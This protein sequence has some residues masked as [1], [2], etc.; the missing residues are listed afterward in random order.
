MNHVRCLHTQPPPTTMGCSR[1]LSPQPGQWHDLMRRVN[2]QARS[3]HRFSSP[4]IHFCDLSGGCHTPFSIAGPPKLTHVPLPKI[5]SCL[6]CE[7]LDHSTTSALSN[8]HLSM[9][10]SVVTDRTTTISYAKNIHW[11]S[12]LPATVT[13]RLESA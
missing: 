4:V 12:W 3:N 13:M 2:H 7:I 11:S 5:L 10:P 1:H 6:Q 9:L 8:V